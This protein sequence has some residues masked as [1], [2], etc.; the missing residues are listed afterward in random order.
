MLLH[1]ALLLPS[2][3]DP[4]QCRV[5]KDV[6]INPHTAGIGH[7]AG[8]SIEQCCQACR[9]PLWWGR[10]CR[11]STLS[12]GAC[13]L[14][15]DNKTVAP[16][17]G[18][19]SVECLSVGPPPPPLPPPPPFPP[20]GTTGPWALLG[21]TN[22]GDDVSLQGEAGTLAD[23]ASPAANPKIMYAGGQNNGASSGV[24][25][26]LDGGAHWEVK[27]KGMWS[28]KVEGVHVV[29]SMGAH[30]LVAVIGAIY[31]SLDYAEHWTMIEGSDKLG[32]CNTFKNGTINGK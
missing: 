23:A 25:R 20:K 16:S 17:P 18:K 12:R 11:F 22:I 28:T 10:G 3:I 27:S 31:E 13:W 29:D 32:T 14:K 4:T 6:D 19:M 1:L 21:P 8:N 15:G 26:S 5:T 2:V 24:H 7:V 9:S 30:V